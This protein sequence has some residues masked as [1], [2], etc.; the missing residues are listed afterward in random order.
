MN[1]PASDLIAAII[2]IITAEGA[3]VPLTWSTG[4]YTRSQTGIYLDTYP[5]EADGVTITDYPVTDD[6][7]LSDSTVGIQFTIKAQSGTKLR[8]ISDDLMDRLHGRPRGIIG[9]IT[10]V[11]SL[12]Q[13]GAVLGQ[14]GK[15]RLGRSEN[16]YMQVWRP[17]PFRT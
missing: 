14:D 17:S 1:A 6:V 16:Y 15:G 5:A 10:L 12:R 9:S 8:A 4:N 3:R 2:Q 7:S 13:S 11:S